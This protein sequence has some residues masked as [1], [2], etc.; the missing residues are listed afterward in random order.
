MIEPW[1]QIF[2]DTHCHLPPSLQRLTLLEGEP[3]PDE[4]DRLLSDLS[5]RHDE[6][7]DELRAWLTARTGSCAL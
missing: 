1:L 3:E 7:C 6:E 4:L 2:S 5:V